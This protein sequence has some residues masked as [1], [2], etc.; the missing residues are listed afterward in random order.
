MDKPQF[1]IALTG[2]DLEG[3]RKIPLRVEAGETVIAKD[4]SKAEIDAL[5]EMNA[6]TLKDSEGE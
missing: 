6:I 2:F 1:Y 5:L 3:K 4:L